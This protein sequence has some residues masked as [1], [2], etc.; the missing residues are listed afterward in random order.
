MLLTITWFPRS[1]VQIRTAGKIVYIDPAYMKVCFAGYPKKIEYSSWPDPI[2]SLPEGLERGDII[3]VTHHHKDH[4]KRGTL[5][6]LRRSD[7]LALATKCLTTAFPSRPC[8]LTI[9]STEAQRISS[10][11]KARAL[12]T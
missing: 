10:I 12:D 2:D 7:T 3:L 6:R 8:Q 1:W 9:L 11:A 5:K 4:C